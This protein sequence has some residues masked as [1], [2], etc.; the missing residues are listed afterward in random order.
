M[1]PEE[2][3]EMEKSI[4]EWKRNALVTTEKGVVDEK[5]GL[6]KGIKSKISE[7]DAAKK[8]YETDE[9]N[10]IKEVRG[11]YKEFKEKL[12]EGM[13]NTQ[14]PAIQRAVQVA[15]LA[16]SESSC[17]R[18]IKSMEQYDPYFAFEEIEV[19]AGDIFR[20]FYCNFLSG[21]LEY[22]QTVA[23]GT[24]L[25]ICKSELMRR[26]KEG[27]INKYDEFLDCGNAVFNSGQMD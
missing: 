9:Y 6:F 13:E 17:A 27:W 26:N 7:T 24:A 16:K 4:P 23:D 2:I 14:N 15:D 22:L 21:N 11:N 1:T 19:E 5:K 3:E 18:A 8:F 25:A 12:R 20:E 10:K